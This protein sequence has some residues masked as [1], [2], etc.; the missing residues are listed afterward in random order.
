[1]FFKIGR[2]KLRFPT[3]FLFAYKVKANRFAELIHIIPPFAEFLVEPLAID[4]NPVTGFVCKLLGGG[5]EPTDSCLN[6]QTYRFWLSECACNAHMR[7]IISCSPFRGK[8]KGA[9]TKPEQWCFRFVR[10]C[11]FSFFKVLVPC[12]ASYS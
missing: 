3:A 1:M 4:D 5:A 2:R 6:F 11:F 12:P 7:K 8:I 10:L 9:S